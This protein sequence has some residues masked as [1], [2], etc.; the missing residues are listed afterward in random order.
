MK[1]FEPECYQIVENIERIR[2]KKNITI[3]DLALDADISRSNVHYI[4]KGKNLPT[5][6]SLVKIAKA[7]NVSLQDVIGDVSK[8]WR[9]E[10]EGL[11]LYKLNKKQKEIITNLVNY[12]LKEQQ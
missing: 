5:L 8:D 7:L 3:D 4:L 11:K 6:N 2:H 12:F 1:E 9:I 10:N